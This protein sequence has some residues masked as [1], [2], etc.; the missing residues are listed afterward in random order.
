MKKTDNLLELNN[1]TRSSSIELLRIIAMFMII[2]HHFAVHGHFI[3]PMTD[4]S[5]LNFWRLFMRIGGKVGVDIFILIS[6]YY[7]I[8]SKKTFDLKKII[9]F[10]LQLLFYSC[11]I[12]IL[13]RFLLHKPYVAGAKYNLFPAFTNMW[14]FAT[15]Y[16]MLFLIYPFLNVLAHNISQDSYKKML[17][18]G[19][20]LYSLLMTFFPFPIFNE[21]LWFIILYLLAAYIR[22]YSWK[23]RKLFHKLSDSSAYFLCAVIP[24][25]LIFCINLSILCFASK[26]N[27]Y[28]LLNQYNSMQSV[29]IVLISLYLWRF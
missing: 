7:L 4:M 5:F 15:C 18:L 24:F 27:F 28:R 22:L 3:S 29:F 21:F 19:L 26:S 6:G 23:P 2:C 12:Y 11:S 25:I 16:F 1:S 20:S 10:N 9:K 13:F 14:W 17:I 8:N